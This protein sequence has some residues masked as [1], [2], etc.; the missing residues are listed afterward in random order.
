MPDTYGWFDHADV[1]QAMYWNLFSGAFGHTYGCHPVWQFKGGK[2]EPVG[3]ARHNW[4]EVLDIE[5]AFDLIHARRL[6]ESF[7]FTS[8]IPDQS[9][10]ITPRDFATDVAVATRGKDYAFVYLP[11][12]HPVEVALDKI[13]GANRLSLQWYNPRTG[14]YTDICAVNTTGT[15]WAD[16]PASGRGNDW[17]LVMNALD[18]GQIAVDQPGFYPE[19][20]KEAAVIADSGIKTFKI[21]TA[22][23]GKEVYSGK[24]NELLHSDIF[25]MPF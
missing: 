7:D 8:R 20:Q 9:I 17:V 25:Q 5:G 2:D 4:D 23:T 22:A 6:L 21:V 13:P 24:L 1:R 10:I 18:R 15:Y 12:G 14:E 19:A 11:N 16:P 3:L